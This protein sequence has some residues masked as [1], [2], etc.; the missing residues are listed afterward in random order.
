MAI[1]KRKQQKINGNENTK[2]KDY[3]KAIDKSSTNGEKNLK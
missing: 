3:K 2:I 1:I